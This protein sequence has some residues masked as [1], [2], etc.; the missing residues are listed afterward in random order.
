MIIVSYSEYRH[1]IQYKQPPEY[2]V[3]PQVVRH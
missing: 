3:L 1:P 2:G